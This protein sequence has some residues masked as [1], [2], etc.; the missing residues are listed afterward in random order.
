[1]YDEGEFQPKNEGNPMRLY[2][3]LKVGCVKDHHE[4]HAQKRQEALIDDMKKI[5]AEYLARAEAAES[6]N[7]GLKKFQKLFAWQDKNAPMGDSLANL[8]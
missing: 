3:N 8:R 4:T 7:V 2:D 5:N 1:M 6:E